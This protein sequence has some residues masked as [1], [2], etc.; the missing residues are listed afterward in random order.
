MLY[1]YIV[2]TAHRNNVLQKHLACLLIRPIS[3]HFHSV[4]DLK[5]NL[6]YTDSRRKPKVANK[7]GFNHAIYAIFPYQY[8][9]AAFNFIFQLFCLKI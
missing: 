2:Y 8:V 9:Y 4:R 1:C 3:D 6:I 7:R 5:K